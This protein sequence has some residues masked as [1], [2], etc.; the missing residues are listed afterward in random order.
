MSRSIFLIALALKKRQWHSLLKI[1]SVFDD[2]A[3]SLN[4]PS[5]SDCLETGMN[6]IETI[7]PI[8]ARFRRYEISVIFNIREEFLQISFDENL[9]S[10]RMALRSE[11]V[12]GRYRVQP[13]S[14]LL[15]LT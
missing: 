11:M 2:S 13:R 8:L 9:T 14:R 6:F 15:I 5:L 3:K 10:V 1:R 4:Y 7:P 12:D